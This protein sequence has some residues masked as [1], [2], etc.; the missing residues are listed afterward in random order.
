MAGLGAA[1]SIVLTGSAAR[2]VLPL[3]YRA[4][5]ENMLDGQGAYFA[6]TC[7]EC[8]AGCGLLVGNFEGRDRTLHGNPL[9][10]NPRHPVGHGSLCARGQ[11]AMQ[12][13]G[14]PHRNREPLKQSG[15]GS[16]SFQA[17]E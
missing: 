1:A 3:S 15:R 4:V 17:L 5:S 13:A 10:G 14:S 6:A 2:H 16:G 7:G 11:A 12:S 8:S 9:R